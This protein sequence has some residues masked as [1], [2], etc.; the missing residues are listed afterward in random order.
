[1]IR[2][3][4]ALMAALIGALLCGFDVERRHDLRIGMTG[5]EMN[6]TISS[7][8][9]RFESEDG[10][11]HASWD[12]DYPDGTDRGTLTVRVTAKDGVLGWTFTETGP[13]PEA[14]TPTEGAE[15]APP[16]AEASSPDY[17]ALLKQGCGAKWG[18]D[19]RMLE[20]CQ[21]KQ[22]DALNSVADWLDG[23]PDAGIWNMCWDKWSDHLHGTPDWT[24][25]H[26]C[27]EQQV[28]ARER[29]RR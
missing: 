4:A 25:V 17:A 3:T 10:V 27:I 15:P 21:G 7:K 12:V 14:P 13:G 2:F 5:D 29:L 26:Y 19:Y 24:M 1:M 20:Y 16:E 6:K 23:T 9:D 11:F 28:G 18:T 22:V 8:P